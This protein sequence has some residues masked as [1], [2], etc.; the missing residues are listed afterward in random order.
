MT[1]LAVPVGKIVGFDA[2]RR[3]PA[4]RRHIGPAAAIVALNRNLSDARG[5]P[6]YRYRGAE[7]RCAKG[8]HPCALVMPGHR[9]DEMTFGVIGNITPLVDLWVEEGRLPGHMR[10][11]PNPGGT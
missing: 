2:V 3:R 7:I 11:A 9:L 4:V 6:V 5:G 1:P 10:A 8:G